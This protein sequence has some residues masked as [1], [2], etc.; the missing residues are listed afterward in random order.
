MHPKI[1]G[2]K[3]VLEIELS[4]ESAPNKRPTSFSSP[5][6]IPNARLCIAGL[7]PPPNADKVV[8]KTKLVGEFEEQRRK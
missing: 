4:I 7:V 2:E 6:S 8:T 5:P 1:I 3:I